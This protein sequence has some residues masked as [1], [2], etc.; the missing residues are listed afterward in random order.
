I[1]GEKQYKR[2]QDMW[3]KE[4]QRWRW[5]VAFPI[6]E[7]YIIIDEP[8]ARDVFGEKLYQRLYQHPARILRPLSNA[9]RAV[10]SGLKIRHIEAPNIKFEIRHNEAVSERNR[11]DQNVAEDFGRVLEGLTVE[12]QV[13]RRS[14]EASLRLEFLNSRAATMHCDSCEWNPAKQPDLC[15]LT[16]RSLFDVHHKR[17]LADGVRDTTLRDLS[18]LCP[19]CHRIV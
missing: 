13:K 4:G 5:A 16:A 17:P 18:L 8:K 1:I 12:Q 6:V 11:I 14:R 19:R 3:A 10:I 15:G 2:T 9:E 7:S